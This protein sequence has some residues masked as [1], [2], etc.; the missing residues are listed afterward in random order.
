MDSRI[1]FRRSGGQIA[2]CILALIG[3]GIAI[4]LTVV[5][6]TNTQVV[7]SANGLVNCELV[8]KSPY[9]YVPGTTVPITIP[10]L[11]WSLVSVGLAASAWLIWPERRSLLMAEVAWTGLGMLTVLYL[12]F[13]EIVRLHTICAWCTGLHVTILVMFLISV[14]LFLSASS[15]EEEFVEDEQPVASTRL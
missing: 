14:V 1:D 5:H 7:C 3:L 10:G 15:E 6:Y 9:A 4:Y 2:L 12:V 13:V 8:L 11:L